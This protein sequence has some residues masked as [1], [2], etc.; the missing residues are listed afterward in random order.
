MLM[1]TQEAVHPY[2]RTKLSKILD[3]P[4]DKL[5]IRPVDYFEKFNIDVLLNTK[6]R[7]RRCTFV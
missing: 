7:Q 4:V 2:D 5:L 3:S 6:V 1:V